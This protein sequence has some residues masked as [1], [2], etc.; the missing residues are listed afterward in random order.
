M[1]ID[2]YLG[3]NM[4]KIRGLVHSFNNIIDKSPDRDNSIVEFF[5]TILESNVGAD[6]YYNLYT[7]LNN[8]Y[9][10][11]EIYPQFKNISHQNAKCLDEYSN[12]IDEIKTIAKRYTLP[13]DKMIEDMIDVDYQV[14][15]DERVQSIRSD[16]NRML[17]L[18]VK[19]NETIEPTA[20][21]EPKLERIK[22]LLRQYISNIK[23]AYTALRKLGELNIYKESCKYDCRELFLVY[24]ASKKVDKN[25]ADEMFENLWIMALNEANI[26]TDCANLAMSCVIRPILTTDEIREKELDRA[27]QLFD[28]YNDV[29]SRL[30]TITDAELKVLADSNIA[31]EVIQPQVSELNAEDVLPESDDAGENTT[32]DL[33]ESTAQDGGSVES[34]DADAS[35]EKV[36]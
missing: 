7:I 22:P 36:N 3:V 29:G 14:G 23:I 4:N 12:E 25:L 5:V 20:T 26:L 30:S 19:A 15:L 24:T 10:L 21:Y 18:I 6:Y 13:I 32:A 27:R 16:I 35:G 34:E 31:G 28:E 2:E 11:N 8:F 33:G 9:S 1:S 17:D